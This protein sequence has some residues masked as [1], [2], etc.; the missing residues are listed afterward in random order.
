MKAKLTRLCLFSLFVLIVAFYWGCTDKYE[1]VPNRF[2][3]EESSCTGCHLNA[4]LLQQL[5]TPLPPDPHDE[6][7]EG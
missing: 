2:A 6:A 1:E 4:T 5:A 3:V 7:G